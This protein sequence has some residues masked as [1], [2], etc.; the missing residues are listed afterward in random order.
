MLEI[1]NHTKQAINKNKFNTVV[2]LFLRAYKKPDYLVTLVL[3][4]DAKM[5]TFNS[6]YRGLDRTTDI[7]SFRHEEYM[8]NILGEIIINLKEAGRIVKYQELLAELKLETLANKKQLVYI[9]YFLLVH[10]LLHLVGYND[11]SEAERRVMIILGKKFMKKI[12]DYGI[13]KM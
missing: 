7:L 5:K 11:D 1:V 4:G 2:E 12:I 10:G 6:R 13:I 9:F 3:T 8:G